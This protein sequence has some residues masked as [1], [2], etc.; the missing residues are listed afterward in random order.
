[1][2]F[3]EFISKWNGRGIDFDGAYGDQCMDLMHQYHVEVLGI[4]DGR[5]LAAPAA[6]DV[7]SNFSTIIGREH[8]EQIKNTPT[9][10]PQKGDIIIWGTGIGP[11]GHIAI[12]IEGDANRFKSFDQNFPTGSK[13]KI[14]DH[15]Y[16]G[17]L[18][19][20]R[21]KG[22]LP[23]EEIPVNTETFEELVTKS[24]SYDQFVAAGFTKVEEVIKA[25]QEKE[26]TIQNQ[27][28][29]LKDTEGKLG[30]C[31]KIAEELNDADK[32][33]SEQ[34]IEAQKE[35]QPYKDTVEGL[36]TAFG[37]PSDAELKDIVTAYETLKESKVKIV[38]EPK[39]SG[40][41]NRLLF[42]LS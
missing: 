12:F 16:N 23:Q 2:T 29:D 17:V 40:F 41:I 31:L 39:P 8:F 42:L 5:T 15:N 34:L 18:G 38:K 11:F 4:T 22:K 33:T 27:A 13:C 37:L 9:G 3:D 1:M 32:S 36:K 30:N 19:W 35:L 14:V 26:N 21:F 24:S 20:L 10:V 7:Y 25:L 6:K 28:R